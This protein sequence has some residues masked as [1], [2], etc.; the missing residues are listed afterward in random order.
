MDISFKNSQG[1]TL[2]G[3]IDQVEHPIAQAIFSHCF[4]CSKDHAASY[5]ICKA[6]AEQHI[7]VLRFDF[8]GLG[9][10][11][12]DF[13]TTDFSSNINDIKAAVEFLEKQH[14]AP[15]LLIGHSLGGIAAV[16][17][18]CELDEI[19]AVATIAAPSRPAH[20]LDHFEQHIPK[21]LK[22][23]F[24]NVLV[25]DRSFK[26]TKEYILNLKDYDER[27]FIRRLNKPILI[28][29]SPYD[30]IV[31]IDEAA[32]IFLKAKHPKS[33]ISLDHADHLISKKRD[34]EYI[35]ENIACWAKRYINSQ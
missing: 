27:H 25:F 4:T 7:Q 11:E 18:A 10:S 12:G 13:S 2:S 20:V 30:D 9:K 14:S 31:S 6:L 5:R 17:A 16:A 19:Q 8:M 15:Q 35:A 22:N 3:I 32:K 29:H 33:F 34:A 24:D 28:F 21:I 23:G 26:F 1:K